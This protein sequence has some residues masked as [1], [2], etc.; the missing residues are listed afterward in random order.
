[1][2]RKPHP[3]DERRR[4]LPPAPIQETFGKVRGSTEVEKVVEKGG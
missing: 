3:V 2:Q 4:E 1:M